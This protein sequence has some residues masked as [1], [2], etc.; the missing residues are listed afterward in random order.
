MNETALLQF[1]NC[2]LSVVAAIFVLGANPKPAVR[3]VRWW[4]A[5]SMFLGAVMYFGQFAFAL[6]N[7]L[8]SLTREQ[9]FISQFFNL[10]STFCLG[11]AVLSY[12]AW[13]HLRERTSA[14]MLALTLVAAA[15][16]DL[17]FSGWYASSAV[18]FLLFGILAWSLRRE[19]ITSAMIFLAYAC[20]QVPRKL[21]P[22]GHLEFDFSLLVATKFA[23]ISAIYKSFDALHE[24][25]IE[26]QSQDG[27]T[28]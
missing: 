23:L 16:F 6:S 9:A 13:W 26:A 4:L 8:G 1:G 27:A 28:A 3:R 12:Y 22:A 21:G 7:P 18:N 10:W 20:L 11:V 25:E 15:A 19:D 14:I 2:V 5:V 17:A 24:R